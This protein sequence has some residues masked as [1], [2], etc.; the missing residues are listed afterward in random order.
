M[1]A[2]QPGVDAPDFTLKDQDRNDVTLS[3]FRGTS[4]VA[5]VFYPFTFTPVCEGELC[6][7]RDDLAR[8]EA[9][10]VQVLAVSCDSMFAQKKWADEMGF[11]FPVL[12]DRWP[13]GA[14]AQAY[15]VFNEALG[16]ANRG[17]FVID[18]SGKIVDSVE[19]ENLGTAREKEWYEKAI[20]KLT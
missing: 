19:T 2:L 12:S 20:A 6:Q 4:A 5:L 15:G 11:T 1:A 9:D 16:V 3:S 17:T 13:T 7:L 8:Y 10:G 18:K 14:V